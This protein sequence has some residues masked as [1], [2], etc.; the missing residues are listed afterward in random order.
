MENVISFVEDVRSTKSD[1]NLL[2]SEKTKLYVVDLKTENLHLS[3]KIKR[4][5]AD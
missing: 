5:F 1:F 3:R 4:L 2:S